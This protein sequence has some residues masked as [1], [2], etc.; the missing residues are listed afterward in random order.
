[1]MENSKHQSEIN[2]SYPQVP[3]ADDKFH[4][5]DLARGGIVPNVG[6]ML[7]GVR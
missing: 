7:G 4:P 1:M 3:V 2:Q 5:D 6:A